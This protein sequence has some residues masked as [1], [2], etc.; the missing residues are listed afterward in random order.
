[1]SRPL[2]ILHA[3]DNLGDAQLT[4]LA[5]EESDEPYELHHVLDG[6]Q[7]LRFLRRETPYEDAPRPDLVL[8]DLN[9][10]RLNGHATIEAIKTDPDLKTV[11]VIVLTTSGSPYDVTRSYEAHVNSYIR[12]PLGFEQLVDLMTRLQRFWLEAAVLPGAVHSNASSVQT[13]W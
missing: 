13:R 8:L 11:P 1:M 10:P 6:E 2:C 12:K 5:L 4:R 3:E 7:A 9:M